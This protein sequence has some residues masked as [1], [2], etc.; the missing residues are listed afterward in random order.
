MAL[1]TTMRVGDA[2]E[3]DGPARVIYRERRG[4]APVVV[5]EA[6]T[7]TT[8]TRVRRSIAP[9]GFDRARLAVAIGD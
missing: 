5:A 4:S 1:V 6:P 9:I 7:T 8:I 3:V 2:V